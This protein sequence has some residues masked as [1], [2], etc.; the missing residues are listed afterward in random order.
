[1]CLSLHFTTNRVNALA[2]LLLLF[3]LVSSEST[4]VCPPSLLTANCTCETTSYIVNCSSEVNHRNKLNWLHDIP[5]E[6]K[7]LIINGHNLATLTKDTFGA[8]KDEPKLV[9]YIDLSNN[10]IQFIDGQT[11]SGFTNV[12]KLILSHNKIRITGDNYRGL[13]KPFVNLVELHLVSAFSDT[14]N[15]SFVPNLLTLLR[16]ANLTELSL[17]SLELNGIHGFPDSTS[18]CFLPSLQKLFLP[19][20]SLNQIRLNFTCTPKLRTLDLSHN[21]I[22][23]LDNESTALLADLPRSF[24][25]NLTGNPFSC[26][27]RSE[28]FL[29]WLKRTPLFI[30]GKD[31]YICLSGYPSSNAYRRLIQLPITD[32]DCDPMENEYASSSLLTFYPHIILAIL[33]VTVILLLA[34]VF[35]QVRS[36]IMTFCL[37]H[38]FNKTN[39][40]YC[41]L[42]R[43]EKNDTLPRKRIIEISV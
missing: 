40:N 9:E 24:H 43:D 30:M 39:A 7:T 17:L 5:I 37:A 2:S 32:I 20:N 36:H 28:H 41:A 11:F 14:S 29:R 1:M 12:K 6:T 8:A 42:R 35:Y 15:P 25:I 27:C 13:F 34:L 3:T 23:H 10:N 38:V 22:K 31:N 18:F 33:T 26:D 19:G 16:E 4:F 21:R